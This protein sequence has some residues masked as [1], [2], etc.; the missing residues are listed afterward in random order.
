MVHPAA[1]LVAMAAKAQE[2]EIGDATNL[3]VVF[4]GVL[5]EGAENLLRQVTI[6]RIHL[7]NPFGIRSRC[8]D[9]M[10]FCFLL[11]LEFQ[12][13]YII[14]SR[15]YLL[16]LLCPHTR[17][18]SCIHERLPLSAEMDFLYPVWLRFCL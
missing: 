1:K 13:E 6:T 5:L 16:L 7:K 17:S 11:R 9:A 10:I 2:D 8:S 12:G 18:S 14:S 15:I 4:A 3:V